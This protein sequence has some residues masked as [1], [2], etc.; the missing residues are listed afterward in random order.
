MA[1]GARREIIVG[2][3]FII[4]MTVLGIYSIALSGVHLA[5]KDVQ[6]HFDAVSGLQVGNVVRVRG[7]DVGKVIDLTPLPN[8]DKYPA[9]TSDPKLPKKGVVAKVSISE[10]IKLFEEAEFSVQ[11]F[12]ALGGRFVAIDP[13][14]PLEAEKPTGDL[15][16]AG[17][18]AGRN[19]AGISEGLSTLVD[20]NR[21][22]I[23][24]TIA[25]LEEVTR[26]LTTTD[27]TA[28]LFINDPQ[29]YDNANE[30]MVEL[31]GAASNLNKLTSD[32]GAL[33]GFLND[34]QVFDELRETVTYAR[35]VMRELETTMTRLNAG[36]GAVGAM[37][38]DP[39]TE[40]NVKGLIKDARETMAQVK[41][42][43]TTINDPEAQGLV[44]RLIHDEKM[45]QD[46]ATTVSNVA[47]LTGRLNSGDS[48][49]GVLLSD[50]T[51]AQ[52]VRNTLA[53]LDAVTTGMANGEGVAGVLLSDEEVAG[54]LR[55]TITQV[56]RL[57]IE[58][59]ESVE[60]AR[61]QAPVNAFVGAVFSAF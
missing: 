52:N 37:L 9:F 24:D 44:P 5:T 28:G 8:E 23:T 13:G 10:S 50:P 27:G 11:N 46:V 43:A 21:Q 38:N 41:E 2:L 30:L 16:P 42:I 15:G 39:D 22:N 47:E 55:E 60:D 6:V 19:V 4:V 14:N 48:A 17:V 61:E 32:E 57:V 20:E 49:L 51:A 26:S 58:L 34:Q 31:K 3:F 45:G 7:V 54:Q 18:F 35:N 1:V 29:L 40:E 25:N 12:S 56:R 59:R 33:G 36:Q 53:N